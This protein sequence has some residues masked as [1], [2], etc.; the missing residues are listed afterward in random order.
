VIDAMASEPHYVQ[1]LAPI[2]RAL[3]PERRARFFVR[4]ESLAPWLRGA[5]ATVGL[6]ARDPNLPPV[7]V[8]SW[9]D[10]RRVR[11]RRSILLEH[12]AGQ[13]YG[14]S[15]YH[16]CYSGG[17]DR[18]TVDFFLCPSE[19]VAARN[20]RAYPQAQ[21]EVTGCPKLDRWTGHPRRIPQDPPVV[22]VSFH[23]EAHHVSSEARSARTWMLPGLEALRGRFRLLGH[24]HPRAFPDLKR[25]WARTG[26]EAVEDFE[27]VLGRADLY[28]VDNSSTGMEAMAAGVPVVW[29]NA[30]WYR[31]EISHGGRFWEWSE[32][33]VQADHPSDLEGAVVEALRDPSVVREAREA[34]LP[35]VYAHLGSASE[36]SARAVEV[37]V[38]E[39]RAA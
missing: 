20:R 39:R 5:E 17:Y 6:P 29:M 9:S 1:H 37:F 19:T 33:G 25:E 24:G 8:A 38:E 10:Q 34:I 16:P 15:P 4:R 23:W 13:T 30:P 26:I 2:W 36:R 32:A 27:E 22:A 18:G 31:R 12:G 7:L 3:D 35:A 21:V 28:L 11:P 14:D